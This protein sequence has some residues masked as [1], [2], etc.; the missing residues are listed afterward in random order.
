LHQAAPE[1]RL[2]LLQ[3]VAGHYFHQQPQAVVA[4]LVR[5]L[6][7]EVPDWMLLVVLLELREVTAH[8]ALQFL[9]H[10]FLL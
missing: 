6:T 5:E 2:R 7:Q 3:V 4:L 10:F 9:N 8:Q 1:H